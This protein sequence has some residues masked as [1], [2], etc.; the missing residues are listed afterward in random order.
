MKKLI[1]VV[2]ILF[3]INSGSQTGKPDTTKANE[4]VAIKI[5]NKD[6]D[7]ETVAIAKKYDSALIDRDT[8]VKALIVK[9]RAETDRAN[10]NAKKAQV[11]T[12]KVEEMESSLRKLMIENLALKRIMLTKV[13]SPEPVIDSS[14]IAWDSLPMPTFINK[15]KKRKQ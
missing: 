15:H 4:P 7:P 3:V 8:K 2:C 9:L 10:R 12:K 5:I 6:D 14:D 1:T 13:I 11:N